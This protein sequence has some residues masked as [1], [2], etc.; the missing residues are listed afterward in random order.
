MA[1]NIFE[2]RFLPSHFSDWLISAAS[3]FFESPFKFVGAIVVQMGNYAIENLE[4]VET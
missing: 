2:I 3:Y 4:I 1:S